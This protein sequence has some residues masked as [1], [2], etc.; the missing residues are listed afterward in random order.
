MGD[1][2]A[3]TRFKNVSKQ[4]KDSLLARGTTLQNDEDSLKLD[5]LMTLCTNLQNRVLD[6]EKTKTNQL[7]EIDSLKKRVKKLKKRNRSRTHKL[8]RLYKVGLS[9]RVE[10]S[11]DKESL[12]EDASKLGRRI[13][14]I[15]DDEDITI[16][17][18]QDDANKEMFDVDTLGGEEVFKVVD[19]AQ[20]KGIVFQEPSKSTTTTISLQQSH[21]KGKGIMIEESVKPKKKDQIRLNEEAAKKLQ[22]EFDEEETR[23]REKVEKEERANIAL[24]ETWDD[25]QAKIDK[26]EVAIDAI[27]LA[28]KSPRIVDWKIHKEGKKSYYQI[29]R[30]DRK[31]QMYMIFSQMLIS[32]DR[33]Y[34]E[35]LYKLKMKC[36]RCKKDKKC[37]NGSYQPRPLEGG[38]SYLVH[39]PNHFISDFPKHSFNDQTTFVV[40]CWSDSEDDSKKE[41]ICLMALDDNEVLSDTP[42]YSSSS[43]DNELWQ[44]EYDKLCKIS[45]RIINKNKQLKAKN[46]ELK[47]EACKLKTRVEQ[48]ERNKEISHEC[49][50]CVNLQTKV[51]LLT[52]KLASFENSSSSSQEMLEMQKPPKNKYGIGYTDDIASTSNT[53]PKKLDLKNA[54]ILSVEP[55]LSVPS[56]SEPASSNEKCQEL[57][58]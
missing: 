25:I 4:S 8:K 3:Q 53:K 49:K 19:A 32:F 28:V 21:D 12:G 24:I 56:A 31:S 45:L 33:E 41:E 15:D 16:V 22:A 30:A 57:K 52:L 47:K 42:Y 7:N 1:T 13:D 9:A 50:S 10:S 17:S 40:G 23:A 54:K 44:N 36:G 35:D 29:V 58:I 48:L 2:I 27:P 46:E 20:V 26:E 43:L 55:A 6:L 11:R 37:W 51:S 5:E 14:V 34:L 39:D 18:V 38:F